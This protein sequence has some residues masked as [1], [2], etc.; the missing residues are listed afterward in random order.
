M[1]QKIT[2]SRSRA[3]EAAS[4]TTP[5]KE[6]QRLEKERGLKRRLG[7]A[8][9]GD[10]S[11]FSERLK[12]ELGAHG[13]ERERTHRAAEGEVTA[14]ERELEAL[15]EDLHGGELDSASHQG[16]LET[17]REVD[18]LSTHRREDERVGREQEVEG[19]AGEHDASAQQELK[20]AS[21]HAA[22]KAERGEG[23]R[24][25]ALEEAARGAIDGVAERAEGL[26]GEQHVQAP[27]A[28]SSK[29]MIAALATQLVKACAVGKDQRARKVMLLDVD[30]PGQGQLRVRITRDGDGVNVRLRASD[31]RTRQLVKAHAG[32]LRDEGARQGV[33]FKH[34][35]VV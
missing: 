26:T 31:E 3:A 8:E 2:S 15:E 9:R 23:P 12:G 27:A 21:S 7:D 5:S 19:S 35:E 28:S 29:E 6:Q 30:L 17:S 20:G 1:T 22:S 24:D 14:Q 18:A 11:S 13:A 32:Q 10:R 16:D 33:V 25:A 4:T 34:I